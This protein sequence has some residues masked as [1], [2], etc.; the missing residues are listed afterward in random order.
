MRDEFAAAAAK[1]AA[2]RSYRH[3]N[4]SHAITSAQLERA[5]LR[6]RDTKRNAPKMHSDAWKNSY[7]KRYEWQRAWLD[8]GR[9][10]LRAFTYN[11]PAP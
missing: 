2:I 10:V 9:E 3:G 8:Y 4:W 5:A 6:L 7:V 1:R 11:K